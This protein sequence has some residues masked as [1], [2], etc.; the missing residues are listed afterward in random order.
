MKKINTL[1]HN[2]TVQGNLVIIGVFAFVL[3]FTLITWG[4]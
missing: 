2:D 1:L 3:T 4:K